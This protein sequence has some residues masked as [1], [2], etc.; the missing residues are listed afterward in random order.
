MSNGDLP[1]IGGTE[2]GRGVRP[3]VRPQVSTGAPPASTRVSRVD[4]DDVSRTRIVFDC[5]V[6]REVS[7]EFI[8]EPLHSRVAVYPPVTT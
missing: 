7:G 5:A 4:T 8:S 2:V 6:L 3:E 1:V